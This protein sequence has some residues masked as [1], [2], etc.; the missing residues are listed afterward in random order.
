MLF[1]LPRMNQEE[2]RSQTSKHPLLWVVGTQR[3]EAS[4]AATACINKKA[5]G[6]QRQN[7]TQSIQTQDVGTLW[8]DF[9]F[10]HYAQP[11]YSTY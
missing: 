3:L 7:S 8:S 1:Q 9:N 2:T 11:C 5:D 4:S 6:Q 10:C